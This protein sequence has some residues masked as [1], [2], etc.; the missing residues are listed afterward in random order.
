MP[1]GKAMSIFSKLRLG[2]KL[3]NKLLFWF[4][5]I[6]MIPMAVS[7]YIGY[8][9]ITTEAENSAK[10]EMKTLAESAGLSLNVF[11]NDRVSD[12]LV[13]A[14]LRPIKE[15]IDVAEVREDAPRCLRDGQLY[16]AYEH[17]L[18][19][20]RGTHASSAP[21]V[22]STSQETMPSG[23]K[24]VSFVTTFRNRRGGTPTRLPAGDSG[25]PPVCRRKCS[26]ATGISRAGAD[27]EDDSDIKIGESGCST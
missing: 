26:G 25:S 18:L 21:L 6:T 24:T 22:E 10:R 16:G 19:T 5:L 14:D 13:W 23:A 7:A 20:R 12:T 1:G 15:A 2:G 9:T 8:Q 17:F 27:R 3:R 4:L 11:M